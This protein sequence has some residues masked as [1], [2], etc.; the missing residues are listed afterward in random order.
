MKVNIAFET[1]FDLFKMK[2]NVYAVVD[3]RTESQLATSRLYLDFCSLEDLFAPPIINISHLFAPLV[4][5]GSGVQ[6]PS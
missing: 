2:F 3:E 1:Q 4:I 5:Q 6:A